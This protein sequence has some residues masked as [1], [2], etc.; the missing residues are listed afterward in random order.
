MS[1]GK[2]TVVAVT[3]S[4]FVLRGGVAVEVTPRKRKLSHADMADPVLEAQVHGSA[5]MLELFAAKAGWL[6]R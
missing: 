3:L 4:L 1:A 5:S 6:L 2:V